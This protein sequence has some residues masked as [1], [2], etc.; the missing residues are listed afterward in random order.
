MFILNLSK[1][2][3]AKILIRN[4]K[5]GGSPA[6][7]KKLIKKMNFIE[8]QFLKKLIELKWDRFNFKKIKEAAK[9][10]KEYMLK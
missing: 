10:R 4:P 1:V 5:N 6:I 8:G 7:D 3:R 9:T 2:I